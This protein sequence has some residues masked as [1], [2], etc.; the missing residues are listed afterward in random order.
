MHRVQ[1]VEQ[2]QVAVQWQPLPGWCAYFGEGHV[3]FDPIH[4]LHCA[5]GIAS[6]GAHQALCRALALQVF[7][8][9]E[10]RT[11]ACIERHVIEEVEDPGLTQRP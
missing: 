9:R 5:A 10:Q 1:H 4:V 11:L 2:R 8:Q 7:E 6:V 3:G